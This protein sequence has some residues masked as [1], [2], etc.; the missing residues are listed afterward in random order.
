[1]CTSCRQ[2]LYYV[3]SAVRQVRKYGH[4]AS[5]GAEDPIQ[6]KIIVGYCWRRLWNGIVNLGSLMGQLLSRVET[7]PGLGKGGTKTPTEE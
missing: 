5:L 2:Y 6:L 3:E 7:S 4:S 1:M